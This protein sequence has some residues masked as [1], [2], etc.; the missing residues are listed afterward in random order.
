[1]ENEGFN[2]EYVNQEKE[3]IKQIIE[4]KK[5]NRASYASF[6]C[7]EEMY[8]DSPIGLYKYGYV[9]DLKDI[10]EKNLY[11]YYKK[12]VDECKIDIFVSGKLENIDIKRMMNENEGIK[13]LKS[14]ENSL[15]AFS[16]FNPPRDTYLKISLAICSISLLFSFFNSSSLFKSYL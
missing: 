8:K 14:R 10:D 4:A 1:M 7:I 16:S 5:D 11:Q 3:N 12:L 13:D 2:K 15:I 6:R 9:E